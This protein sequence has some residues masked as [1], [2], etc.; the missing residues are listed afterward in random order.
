MRGKTIKM[1]D[2]DT[3]TLV[4]V[5]KLT[6]ALLNLLCLLLARPAVTYREINAA[7]KIKAPTVAVHRLRAQL[8]PHKI[9]IESKRHVGY[10][11]SDKAKAKVIAVATSTE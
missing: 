5:F 11:L 7:L 4:E 6:P 1:N 10:W 2:L 3:E 8:D 9:P